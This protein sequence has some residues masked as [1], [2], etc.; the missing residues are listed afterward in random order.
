MLVVTEK[1]EQSLVCIHHLW[2]K[3]PK[4]V[5]FEELSEQTRI[6]R[7]STIKIIDNLHFENILEFN[8]SSAAINT[9]LSRVNIY[10]FAMLVD[11]NFFDSPASPN[12]ISL[13]PRKKIE[14]VELLE[15]Y[16]VRF[17]KGISLKTFFEEWGDCTFAKVIRIY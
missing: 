6:S 1:L 9:N 13:K 16:L 12:I 10:D 3:R 14:P 4:P 17:L 8:K 7:K 11:D 5:S 2:T 15:S